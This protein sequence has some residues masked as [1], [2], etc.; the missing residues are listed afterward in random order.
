MSKQVVALI[1]PLEAS[2]EKVYMPSELKKAREHLGRAQGTGNAKGTVKP[3]APEGSRGAEKPKGSPKPESSKKGAGK[4]D[5]SKRGGHKPP[6]KNY[7][8]AVS[9]EKSNAVDNFLKLT[10]VATGKVRK[11]KMDSA[12]KAKFDHKGNCTSVIMN[13]K[14]YPVQNHLVTLP[15]GV[16]RYSGMTS[17]AK[18][19]GKL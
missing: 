14:K 9:G 13:G 12:H 7:K 4:A 19:V 10:N 3:K 6:S 1:I 2:K 18:L 11:M 17:V 5:I 8:T 16:Y 15:K